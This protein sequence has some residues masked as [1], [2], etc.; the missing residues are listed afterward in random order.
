MRLVKHEKTSFGERWT[1]E[2]DEPKEEGKQKKK[3]KPRKK[4]ATGQAPQEKGDGIK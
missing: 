2:P 3:G 4:A 1:Y